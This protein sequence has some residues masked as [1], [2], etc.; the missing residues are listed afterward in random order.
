MKITNLIKY[1]L[2]IIFICSFSFNANAFPKKKHSI[3]KDKIIKKDFDEISELGYFYGY[4]EFCSF[5]RT[6]EKETYKRVKG[7]VAYVNWD[8]FLVFNKGIQDTGITL[9]RAG[10]G[11]SGGSRYVNNY[12]NFDDIDWKY[13]IEGCGNTNSMER[14]YKKMDY[15]ISDVLINFMLARDD[16][17]SN[18]SAL[19]SALGSDKKDDYGS[20]IV[21]VQNASNPDNIEAISEETEESETDNNNEKS[22]GDIRSQLKELKSLFE[23]DLIS[24]DEYNDKKKELL[25]KL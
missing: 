14:A 9:K 3:I 6:E 20:I 21:R 23:D 4:L 12:Y 5:A 13:D 16:F 15:L 7:L 24:E 17:D 19:I 18:L 1:F 11:W 25:D 8:L 10:V 2:C 22:D